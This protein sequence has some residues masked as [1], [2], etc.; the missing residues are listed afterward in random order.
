MTDEWQSLTHRFAVVP[1]LGRGRGTPI[2]RRGTFPG[3]KRLPASRPTMRALRQCSMST[4]LREACS[5]G[6][7]RFF[8]GIARPWLR[9][10]FLLEGTSGI[11]QARRFP[12]LLQC[13]K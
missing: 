11:L 12:E 6:L 10:P 9:S 13:Q 5:S 4:S 2:D 1:H 3:A 8:K 7:P